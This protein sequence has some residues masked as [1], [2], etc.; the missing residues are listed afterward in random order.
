LSWIALRYPEAIKNFLYTAVRYACIDLLR[1]KS[2]LTIPVEAQL[3]E[4]LPD[5]EADFITHL[6]EAEVMREIYSAAEHLPQQIKKVFQLYFVE[7]KSER[8][9]SD[10]LKTSYNTVRKQ[11]Q[12]AVVLLKEKL[13]TPKK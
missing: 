4:Y 7:G 13:Q 10:E 12:R 9:I 5:T 2:I 6:V 8:E 1:K 3:E 11:R